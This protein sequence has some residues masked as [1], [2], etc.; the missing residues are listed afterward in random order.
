VLAADEL[1]VRAAVAEP[2]AYLVQYRMRQAEVRLADAPD[3]V[4]QAT[5]SGDIP[6]ATRQLPSAALADH[7]G[8]PY[9]SDPAEKDGLHSLEPV[10]LVDLTL[11]GHTL[12]RV[13]GRAWVRFDH[14]SEPLA[15]Q[16]YRR[17]AQLFLQHFA[18]ST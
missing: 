17:A 12:K 13:G 3:Q 4:L 15:L 7:G 5:R 8:G 14:G 16:A 6:A 1:R 2:D 11:P 10:F 9:A 18:P